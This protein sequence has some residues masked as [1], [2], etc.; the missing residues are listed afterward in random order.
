MG[1]SFVSPLAQ[2]KIDAI[3][4]KTALMLAT[5][6]KKNKLQAVKIKHFSHTPQPF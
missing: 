1:E 2:G 6:R 3:R 5:L 4:G